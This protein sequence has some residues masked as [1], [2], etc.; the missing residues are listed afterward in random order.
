M[1]AGPLLMTASSFRLMTTASST[2]TEITSSSSSSSLEDDMAFADCVEAKDGETASM[3]RDSIKKAKVMVERDQEQLHHPQHFNGSACSLF[4]S[5]NSNGNNTM[6]L[7]LRTMRW[8]PVKEVQIETMPASNLSRPS[9]PEEKKEEDNNSEDQEEHISK[10]ESSVDS[11][12]TIARDAM[13]IVRVADVV[14]EEATQNHIPLSPQAAPAPPP[15]PAMLLPITWTLPLLVFV[16]QLGVSATLPLMVHYYRHAGVGSASQREVLT[17]LYSSAQIVSGL[18]LGYVKEALNISNRSI[19]WFSFIGSF[20]SYGMVAFSTS[21]AAPPSSSSFG[22]GVWLI[23]LSRILIGLVK[24]TMTV[25]TTLLSA[26]ISAD[27]YSKNSNHDNSSNTTTTSNSKNSNAGD[28][29]KY[30]GRLRASST[31]AWIA[32]P[33]VGALLFNYVH[34]RAPAVL[35]CVLFVISMALL[36]ILL[37]PECCAESTPTTKTQSLSIVPRQENGHTRRHHDKDDPKPAPNVWTRIRQTGQAVSSALGKILSNMQ[38][39][40]CTRE[41]AGVAISRV[42]LNFCW[43]ATCFNKLGSFFDDMYQ[44]QAPHFVGFIRSYHSLLEFIVQAWMV[45]PVLQL[46]GRMVGGGGVDS[47]LANTASLLCFGMAAARI[48]Q[49]SLPSIWYYLFLI[50]PLFSLS[51]AMTRLSLDA[52]TTQVA[53]QES[54]FASLAALDM[55]LSLAQVSVPFYRTILFRFTAKD[56]ITIDGSIVPGG[57]EPNAPAWLIT[58]G[59]HWLVAAILMTVLL[60]K[61]SPITRTTTIP[62]CSSTTT[63]TKKKIL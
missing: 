24:Q 46:V 53:P 35:S 47:S 38:L 60:T 58:G 52:L 21:F 62:N 54:M 17:S 37:P 19:L 48:I 31:M 22:W 3:G 10:R 23:I 14:A 20:V 36:S 45:R 44:L 5:S 18:S 43:K 1:D 34:P 28:R 2:T 63:T 40:F 50:C 39:V 13:N 49:A 25:A 51:F 32:G 41:F 61:S 59:F 33:S 4:R 15:P 9:A 6:T 8:S 29:A 27:D 56:L 26:A 11:T 42:A 55:L 30:V 57:G 12:S 16:D 7:L